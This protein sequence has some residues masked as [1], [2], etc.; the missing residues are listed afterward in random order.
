VHTTLQDL[1]YAV[2]LLLRDRLF[3]FMAMG[4]LAVGIGANTAIFALVNAV[5][6][7]P[8]PYRDPG[9]IVQIEEIIPAITH[10]AMAGTP[11]DV[12]A[13]QR[14]SRAFSAVAG[15]TPIAYDLT[16]QGEPERLPAA[17]VSAELF[18]VLGVQ[19]MLGRSFTPAEDHPGSGVAV[20]SYSLWQRRFGGGR[21]VAGSVV[22]LDRQPTRILGVMPQAF[23]FPLP[24][25]YFGGKAD[26]WVPM[27]FTPHELS[28]IGLYNFAMIG[29]L[30]PGVSLDQAQA[31]VRAVAH[32]IEESYPP[33]VRSEVSLEAQVA[34]V[35]R[36]V[37]QGPRD[38]LG[39]LAGAVAFVLLIACVNCASL[40]V[41]R[42]VGRERELTVRVALGASRG[43]LLR[44]LLTESVLLG[45]IGGGA[46]LLLAAWLVG[47]LAR[48]MP[49]SVPRASAIG[50]DWRVAGFTAAVALFAGL[51]FG[52]APA[53]VAAHSTG[54]GRWKVRGASVSH[55]RARLR[56]FL[57][58]SEVALSMVLLVGAG[59]LAR[60]LAALSS[61]RPGFHLEHVLT[62][63]VALPAR[64]Y[65]DA[66]SIRSFYQRAIDQLAALPGG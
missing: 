34:P 47:L 27:G 13:F 4:M 59:L 29:R 37:L 66:A 14:N 40:L 32:G 12:L 61:V 23:D 45:A 35:T 17:R 51:I 65:G 24:G 25:M 20:I 1:R 41:A 6:L 11:Q 49:V 44:Q 58:V 64:A 10:Q 22:S 50:L 18:A 54:S 31:D 63:R 33:Q 52:T 62:G 53:L 19:P 28:P 15:F 42:A 56:G 7:R 39:L 3:S 30:K 8:L 16:G 36:R 2:R 60:S 46:G 21:G 43:R 9:R 48:V 26:V 55:S 5:L 57:V 38:L